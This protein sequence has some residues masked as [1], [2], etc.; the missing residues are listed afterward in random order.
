MAILTTSSHLS[1]SAS[2][3]AL[4]DT[5]GRMDRNAVDM[6]GGDQPAQ[7]QRLRLVINLWLS[8]ISGKSAS[9]W[10]WAVITAGENLLQADSV[11]G[12]WGINLGP[13]KEIRQNQLRLCAME[14]KGRLN[15][16]W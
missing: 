12:A 8:Q 14:A 16:Q 5:R 4:Y 11:A 13:C 3:L 7:R 6:I 2:V 15:A 10:R 1:R 9:W